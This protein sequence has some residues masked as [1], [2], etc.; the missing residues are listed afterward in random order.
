MSST[1]SSESLK[2]SIEQC[3][4][5]IPDTRITGKIAHKLVDIITISLLAV[6]CGADG[7]VGIETYGQAKQT[8]LE[9]FLELPNG[10]PSHDTFARVISRLDPEMLEQNFQAWV[11]QMTDSLG[12]E[13]VAIDGKTLKGSYDRESSLKCLEMVSA[14]S[15]SHR[16]VLGQVAVDQ[17]S[18][19]IKAIP[20][21]LEQLDLT[22][23]IITIDAMGTQTAIAK[24]IQ[25]A[26]ADYI[27]T[28][29]SNHPSLAH[30]AQDWFEQY[31]QQEDI[32]LAV[33]TETTCE[34]GHHRLERRQFWQVPVELVFSQKRI[35]QWAGLRTLVIEES[36]RSLWNKQTS[37]RRFF[38]SSKEPGF[39]HCS[40]SIRSHWG[41]ENQLHWCLDVVFAED[42]CRLRKDNAPRNMTILRRLALNLLRQDTSKGSL[43][44]KRYQAGL[45]NNFLLQILA[46]SSLF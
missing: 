3:F 43:K 30:E 17:K 2:E 22:G 6:I 20:V 28:L 10:I 19:E 23:A 44:M 32:S 24:Q 29:K 7:W 27:L 33:V 1:L 26:G 25:E 14:W 37:S 8:W 34:A 42:N 18:N 11:K 12:L 40:T 13:V 35:K 4:G 31:Q 5:E 16:L 38:L 41:I 46:N 15:S 39:E 21:L 9:T 36:N 45:D